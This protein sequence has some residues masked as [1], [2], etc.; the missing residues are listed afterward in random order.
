MKATDLRIGNLLCAS[1]GIIVKVVE[2]Q[3]DGYKTQ[4]IIPIQNYPIFQGDVIKPRLPIPLTE[5]WLLRFSEVQVYEL[6]FDLFPI[7]FGF[8]VKNL[9][10][11]G[12]YFYTNGTNAVLLLYVHQLQNFYHALTGEELT[13]KE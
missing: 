4:P 12:Y 1:D 13:I 6:S 9:N 2:I 10:G 3:E 5:D 7:K 11:E 8:I